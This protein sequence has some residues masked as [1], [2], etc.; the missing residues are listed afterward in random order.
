MRELVYVDVS[1]ALKPDLLDDLLHLRIR[2]R[3]CTVRHTDLPAGCWSGVDDRPKKNDH[4]KTGS[5]ALSSAIA[6]ESITCLV[7]ARVDDYRI[8]TRGKQALSRVTSE[9]R[10]NRF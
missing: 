9:Q 1:S 3:V 10:W 7:L 4:A 2:I 6:E 8:F 5:S